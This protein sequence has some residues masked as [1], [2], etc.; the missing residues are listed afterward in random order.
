[1]DR[2]RK[3]VNAGF[4]VEIPE[5]YSPELRGLIQSL[6]STDVRFP[7]LCCKSDSF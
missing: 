5:Q 6:V 7:R 1:M 4:D 3:K 2:I